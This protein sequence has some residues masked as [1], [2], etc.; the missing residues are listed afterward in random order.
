MTG[1]WTNESTRHLLTALNEAKRR[2][3][4]AIEPEHLFWSDLQDPQGIASRAGALD[5]LSPAAVKSVVADLLARLPVARDGTHKPLFSPRL[6]E[7]L[8]K[9][10]SVLGTDEPLDWP[11]VV[12]ALMASYD[13]PLV[14]ALRD[15]GMETGNLRPLAELPKQ[16][17]EAPSDIP[18]GNPLAEFCRDLT[19]LAE[20][21][22]VEPV[23]G[24]EKEISEILL[25]LGQRVT[26]NPLLLGEPGVG[27]TAIVEGLAM[28]VRSGAAPR[29]AGRRFVQLDLNALLAGASYRGEFEER[30]KRV[31][32]VVVAA[33][34][35]YV[36]FVDEIH[37]LM[38][39]GSTVGGADAA[40]LLKPPLARG[41]LSMVGAT[42]YGEYKKYLESDPAFTRRFQVVRVPEPTPLQARGILDGVIQRY[43]DHHGV[44][45]AP[46]AL[47]LIVDLSDRYI[48][49]THFPDKALKVL[50]RAG[51]IAG[52]DAPL[53]RGPEVKTRQRRVTRST[54]MNAVSQISNLPLEY[55]AQAPESRL[56]S[57]GKALSSSLVGQDEPIQHVVNW[58]RLALSAL[59]NP[60]R[61]RGVLLFS[62]P[63]SVGKT[64]A[65][66][67]LAREVYAQKRALTLDMSG[68]TEAT[69]ISRLIGTTAGYVGYGE[70]GLLTEALWRAPYSLVLLNRIEQAH[71]RVLELLASAFETGELA[72]GTGKIV[73]MTECLFV[74]TSSAPREE[75]P[76]GVGTWVDQ[77]ILFNPLDS[78]HAPA[79][80]RLALERSAA[81]LKKSLLHAAAPPSIKLDRSAEAVICGAFESGKGA[82]GV[83]RYVD[84]HIVGA[85]VRERGGR[86]W[87]G[88]KEIVVRASAGSYEFDILPRP[89]VG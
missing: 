23:I 48:G 12:A 11:D 7:M 87:S 67:I 83:E 73:R 76:A 51:S 68:F 88:V 38:G 42:T 70:G 27:K 10:R 47:D 60:V 30:L 52:T 28:A 24:R 74:M 19:A 36:L 2:N 37:T 16:L 89:S 64:T 25:I 54:V 77:D 46:D 69:S 57:L 20:Q 53:N 82:F 32:D 5:G 13:D 14:I 8:V 18:V 58:M 65:A 15:A 50:D 55:I 1:T 62:G 3:N 22:R 26:N 35:K 56:K 71:P 39:A 6:K 4:A 66:L 33:Q 72:D 29:L 63:R 78:S 75:L 86:G 85:L 43:A 41:Q 9:A 80:A 45:Y 79:L 44:T 34:G 40:N 49:S 61:P 59:R 81:Y 31:V 84:E 21:D 17:G